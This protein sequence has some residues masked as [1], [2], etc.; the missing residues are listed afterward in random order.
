MAFNN[1]VCF[2]FFFSLLLIF[3][4]SP[5][6]CSSYYSSHKHGTTSKKSHHRQHSSSLPIIIQQQSSSSSSFST[7]FDFK[8]LDQKNSDHT[9]GKWILLHKSIGISAM[10]MQLLHNNKVVI[11]DR[12]DFGSSNLSLPQGQCRY[13]WIVWSSHLIWK[14][15][16]KACRHRNY[17]QIDVCFAILF[18]F[19]L[20]S[21][22]ENLKFEI[23]VLKHFK[24][25]NTLYQFP[26][27]GEFKILNLLILSNSFF[28]FEM[29]YLHT[30]TEFLNTN[31][32]LK[33]KLSSSTE[34]Q[35]LL[36][37]HSWS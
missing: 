12:T 11:F 31:I 21:E 14:L 34:P 15:N 13:D 22:I 16:K 25:T 6:P 10:H 9:K 7:S 4:I 20:Q 1:I 3:Q 30:L 35:L 32:K 29:H 23:L 24:P 26:N 8:S 28:F 36:W 33:L 19:Q 2:S 27:K 37:I 17:L 5:L 18:I